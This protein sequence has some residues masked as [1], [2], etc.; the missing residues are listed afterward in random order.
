MQFQ[1]RTPWKK[2]VILNLSHPPDG[3]SVNDAI[4]KDMYLGVPT[5]LTFPN[6][7]TL[8]ELLLMQ[9]TGSALMKVD[10]KKYYRQIYYDPGCV[11]LTGF[12]IDGLFYWGVTLSMGLR[13]A[14]YIAQR[15]SNALVF[16][17]L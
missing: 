3:S 5:E 8:V 4:N 17:L 12:V 11:H 14:C 6:V 16:I 1:K 10:L 7:D 13:I 9:G 2:R 15:I